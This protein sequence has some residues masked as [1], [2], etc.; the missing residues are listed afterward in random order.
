MKIVI[1]KNVPV[2][3]RHGINIGN[4]YDVLER[5]GGRNHPIFI[6]GDAGTQVKVFSHEYDEVPEK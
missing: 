3:E 5:E 1:V 4:V 6:M 2:A